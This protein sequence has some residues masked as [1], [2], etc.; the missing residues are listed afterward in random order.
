MTVTGEPSHANPSPGQ[1]LPSMTH[2]QRLGGVNYST[3]LTS[4]TR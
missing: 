2:A 1:P 3:L 4:A